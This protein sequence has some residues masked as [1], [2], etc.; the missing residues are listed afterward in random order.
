[1][2]HMFDGK[3]GDEAGRIN[4]KVLSMRETAIGGLETAIGTKRETDPGEGELDLVEEDMRGQGAGPIGA[5]KRDGAHFF[6][7]FFNA[8]LRNE[9][10][11]RDDNCWEGH[12]QGPS[13]LF[14]WSRSV[15]GHLC[16]VVLSLGGTVKASEK[17][18][19]VT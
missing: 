1:M 12:R 3:G 7:Y 19:L 6:F 5:V 18:I 9:W 4:L 11:A 15:S 8:V 14:I 13:M 16:Q 10:R 2:F 17:D